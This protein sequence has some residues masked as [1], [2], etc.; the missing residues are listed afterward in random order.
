MAGVARVYIS[1][2]S[3]VDRE[4]YVTAALDAL[5]AWFQ[6]LTISPVYDSEAVGFDG[7][8]FLNLVVGVDTDLSVAELSRRFKQLEADNG[9]RRDV[10]KFSART[11]DLDILT[12]GDAVG[13][14]DGVELPRGEILK[15]AFVL[16]PLADIAPDDVH[17]V[18]GKAYG[19]LW[20]EYSTGQKLRPVDFN[21][22]GRQISSSA[23]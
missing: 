4:R 3:N 23:G 19:Q 18:C 15:N 7:S 2:G 14:V 5:A 16:R 13:R 21:W 20:R 9:R 22:Q 10:P 11:L 6:K 12:Y 1:I 17:P 8:P